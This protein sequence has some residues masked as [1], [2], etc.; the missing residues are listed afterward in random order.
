MAFWVRTTFKITYVD[1]VILLVAIVVFLYSVFT[2][3]KVIIFN[4]LFPDGKPIGEGYEMGVQVIIAPI[5]GIHRMFIILKGEEITRLKY[6]D[7]TL[8]K[9]ILWSMI[10]EK[11]QEG[12][13]ET[14][15]WYKKIRQH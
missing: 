9:A 14:I 1:Y 7:W 11:I 12:K 8:Y 3:E 5:I 15:K 2:I 10:L 6:V 4:P 13:T